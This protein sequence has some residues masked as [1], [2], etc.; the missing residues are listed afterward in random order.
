MDKVVAVCLSREKGEAKVAVPEAEFR[1][2]HGMEGDAHAGNWHRQVSFLAEEKID[3]M[4][5]AGLELDHGAFGENLVVRGLDTDA[6]VVGDRVR[7]GASVLLEVTRLGK[8]CHDHCAIFHQVGRCI[9]PES[10][11]FCRVIEGGAV[12]AGDAMQVHRG[13]DA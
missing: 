4:R 7:V 9:M 11:I 2:G 12:K 13:H 8:E 3:E 1:Q 10:G 5:A 6:L